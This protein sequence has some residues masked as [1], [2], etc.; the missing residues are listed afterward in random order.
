MEEAAQ[1]RAEE[2]QKSFDVT[3]SVKLFKY[4]LDTRD[5]IQA[6]TRERVYDEELSRLA[7]AVDRAA[8]TSFVLGRQEG[9]L[10]YFDKGDWRPYAGTLITGLNVAK[11]EAEQDPRREFLADRAADDLINGYKLEGLKPGQ[12]HVW[13]SPYPKEQEVLYGRQFVQSSGFIP[14]RQ[15]GFLYHALCQEDGSVVLESQTVDR[16]DKDAFLY[17]MKTAEHDPEISLDAMT[18]NFD[19]VLREKQGGYFFAGRRDSEQ[20]ENAWLTI[21]AHRDLI[22]YHLNELARL[23]SLDITDSE[24]EDFTRIH[25][26]GVWKAFKN[27]IDNPSAYISSGSIDGKQAYLADNIPNEVREAYNQVVLSGEVMIGCGGSLEASKTD[28]DIFDS[29]FGN[30]TNEKYGFNIKMFCNACQAPPDKGESKKY[31]GPCGLCRNCDV[32]ARIGNL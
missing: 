28:K 24:L 17:V 18:A 23:A 11:K 4:D 10:V 30:K 9:R 5:E 19:F 1:P 6:S 7:E 14:D 27:R 22:E 29:I 32:K 15:M 12:Q 21:K 16:S 31:C 26:I 3:A 13:Y 2:V 25:T 8:R 20:Q